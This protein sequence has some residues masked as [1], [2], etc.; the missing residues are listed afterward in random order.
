MFFSFCVDS[1]FQCSSAYPWNFLCGSAI[2]APFRIAVVSLQP[3]RCRDL[4][5]KTVYERMK[6]IPTLNT[7][8]DRHVKKT[9]QTQNLQYV[10]T[11][12]KSKIT[13]YRQE[14]RE[15]LFKGLSCLPSY[16]HNF[17]RFESQRTTVPMPEMCAIIHPQLPWVAEPENYSSDAPD[18]CHHTPTTSLGCR[19]RELL[20]RCPR[21]VPSYTHNFLGLQSQR[22]TV[23]MPQMCAIIYQQL[24][25]VAEPEN[26]YSDA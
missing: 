25:W 5:H 7:T 10:K 20:F 11:A 16:I 15:L 12:L 6:T 18:V 13:V 24:P 1:S 17:L 26:Y 22:T 4:K 8:M 2:T 9:A 3:F 21:C 14:S 23:Q 19:A